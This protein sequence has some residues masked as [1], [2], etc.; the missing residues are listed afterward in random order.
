M[1]SATGDNPDPALYH[2]FMIGRQGLGYYRTYWCNAVYDELLDA[3]DGT[4]D[5][6]QR[7]EIF[8]K[9]D[10]IAVDEVAFIPTANENLMFVVNP[11]FK[12]LYIPYGELGPNV[13]RVVAGRLGDKAI[14]VAN[15]E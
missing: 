12:G 6:A 14:P 1:Y 5:P 7:V 4:Q 15:G 13:T 2:N 10:R 9:L 3:S 11:A 8:R